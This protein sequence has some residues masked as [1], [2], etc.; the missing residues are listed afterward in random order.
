MS[1]GDSNASYQPGSRGG[2]GQGC[3]WLTSRGDQPSR[4]EDDGMGV[5][6]WERA[7]KPLYLPRLAAY[8]RVWQMT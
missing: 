5:Q 2:S 3:L 7:A 6:K 8:S 4:A 1:Y